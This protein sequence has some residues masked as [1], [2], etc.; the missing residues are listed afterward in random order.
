MTDYLFFKMQQNLFE[1]LPTKKNCVLREYTFHKDN[2][3]HLFEKRF[4]KH[5]LKKEYEITKGYF[6]AYD[7]IN[8]IN[9]KKYEVKRDYWWLTTNNVLVEEYFNYEKR[10]KGWLYETKADF[11]I[12]FVT[13]IL[14]YLLDM[15]KVKSDFENNRST[16]SRSPILQRKDRQGNWLPRRKQFQTINYLKNIVFFDFE[17][18]CICDTDVSIGITNEYLKKLKNKERKYILNLHLV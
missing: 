11:L 6:P 12:V 13:D 16:W 5:Y 4:A 9:G 15:H 2:E 18:H 7:V 1:Y 3:N 14:Y 17:Y 8:K 10:K